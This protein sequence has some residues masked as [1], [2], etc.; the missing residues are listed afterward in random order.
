MA[1]DL[2]ALRADTPGCAEVVHLNNAG[3]GLACT[4]VVDAV[5]EH[6]RREARIGAYEA[7]EEAEDAIEGA[8]AAVAALIGARPSEIALVENA[9]RAW[10]MAFYSLAFEPGDRIITSTAEY[11]SNAIALLQVCQRSG[12]VIDVVR[13]D[14]SGQ[15][16]LDELEAAIGPRTRLIALTHVP[17]QGGLVNPAAEV[18]A[19]AKAAGVPFLLDA[20]Q[21]VGQLRVDV[22]VIGCDYLAAPGRKYLR[23]PR[24][25]AFLYA[26]SDAAGRSEPPFLDLRA[27]SWTAP[28]RYEVRTDAR[29]FES[30][31][32]SY[33]ARI[34][35]G[36]AV[37]YLLALG[38]DEVEARITELAAGLR[39]RL[40]ARP[41]T[42]VHDKG[43]RRCGIVTFT[44]D[45]HAARDVAASLRAQRINVSVSGADVARHDFGKRG[46]D[47]VVRASV[48]YYNTDE[49]IDRL[50]DA[51]PGA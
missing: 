4:P 37:D 38:I 31:E 33:A 32:T 42:H 13:D 36:V 14:D 2:D 1:L 28:G 27:A 22:D 25:T 44:V 30:W 6:L 5:V 43:E 35:F 7:A 46:L 17:S 51:L 49:E 39:A 3:A 21:S 20:S 50:V 45:G 11:A 40:E 41:R 8:Y 18:G 47:E 24:G 48:H 12:A 16:S 26:R 34:G 9:T 23:G 19:L 10:D 29:R 15:V